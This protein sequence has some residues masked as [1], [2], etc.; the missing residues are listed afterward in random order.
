MI[1]SVHD[2]MQ[3]TFWR[4]SIHGLAVVLVL[5]LNGMGP[6]LYRTGVDRAGV[7]GSRLSPPDANERGYPGAEPD[8]VIQTRVRE[9]YNKVPLTLEVNQGQTDG[10]VKFL[11]RGNGSTLFLTSTEAVLAL[12]NDERGMMND[13]LKNRHSSFSIHHPSFTSRAVVRMK[14]VGANTDPSVAGVDPQPGESHYFIGNDPQKWRTHIPTY[15]KVKYQ[16]VYPGIDVVYYGNQRQLEYDLIVGSGA[17]PNAIRLAFQG[18]DRLELD[19]QGD[20][21]LHTAGGRLRQHKPRIYQEVAG[22]RREISGRY[23]LKNDQQIGFDVGAYDPARPLIIDPTLVYSTYLGSS[24]FDQ[25]R[26]I[27]VDAAGNAYVAGLTG[28]TTFPIT[29]SVQPNFGGGDSDAFVMKI[30]TAGNTMVYST[31]LGGLFGDGATAVAVDGAG[32]AYV[33]G[34][35]G[36]SDFPTKTP[37]QRALAGSVDAFI[38]KVNATGDA[39]LYST[40][41]GGPD[42]DNGMS[43]AVDT[44]GNASITGNTLSL[45]FPTTANPLQPHFSGGVRFFGGDA[46]VA[47]LSSTGTSLV[48]STYLGGAGEDSG[49]HIAVDGAGNAYVTGETYSTNFPTASPLQATNR[50]SQDAFVAKLD[51]QGSRLVYSTYLGGSDFERGLGIAVDATGNAYVTGF[52]DSTNFPTTVGAFVRALGGPEDGYVAKLNAA[53]T[54]L[55]YSTYLGGSGSDQSLSVAI[56]SSGNAYVTGLTDSTNF[57]QVNSVQAVFGG[58][59]DAFITK[60]GAS[61]GNLVYS[62]YFGGSN[63]E[64][65]FGIAVDG[66]GNAYVAGTTRSTNFRTAHALQST[67]GGNADAFVVKIS[68]P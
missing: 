65:G 35:T 33:T 59:H 55:V 25:S 62:T 37:L 49:Q 48:Y 63:F 61:G 24:S 45:D 39:L 54:A 28:S 56:D 2:I 58:D 3:R 38:A 8:A 42:A 44:T 51:P 34:S 23:V 30:N 68:E 22:I 64:M 12:G 36:S 52:T 26:G 6:S 41:L 4:K 17:D 60:V 32:N 40:Y 1:T 31:Y 66:S 20:L 27:A 16:D 13:E 9:A 57:P 10:R 21:V 7:G 11:A 47:K 67:F 29:A 18:A 46:F 43:I 14:L 50:G 5:A 15:A 19:A 53:G